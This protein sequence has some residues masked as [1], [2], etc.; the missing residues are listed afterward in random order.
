M[1]EKKKKFVQE[2]SDYDYNDSSIGEIERRPHDIRIG[3]LNLAVIWFLEAEV[4]QDIRILTP[5]PPRITRELNAAKSIWRTSDGARKVEI[6]MIYSNYNDSNQIYTEKLDEKVIEEI[7]KIGKGYYKRAD[8]Y[9]FYLP[10][11]LIMDTQKVGLALDRIIDNEHTYIVIMSNGARARVEPTG[12]KKGNDYVLAHE[13]GHIL[14]CTNYYGWKQDPK[15]NDD[16]LKGNGKPDIGHH[17]DDTEEE[18]R[19][20]MAPNSLGPGVI[21]TINEDQ[22]I[23]ALQSRFCLPWNPGPRN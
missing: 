10:G 12:E 8:A 23:R 17:D 14:Y 1:D 18:R 4:E 19:N 7:V 13:L 11:N 22:L 5:T 3:S 6:N 9:V 15:P 16:T 20:L 21:P 2:N